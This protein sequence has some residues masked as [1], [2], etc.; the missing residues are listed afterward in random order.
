MTTTAIVGTNRLV[1]CPTLIGWGEHPLLSVATKPLRVTLTTPPNG[2]GGPCVRV[3]DNQNS[4]ESENGLQVIA[5]PNSVSIFLNQEP[6]VVATLL[7]PDTIHI[8]LDLRPLG[9]VLYEDSRGL[10][11]GT[12]VL[13]HNEIRNCNIAIGIG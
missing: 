7:D 10:L 12:N 9:L 3:K 5:E 1:D 2:S 13:A 4:G 8:K 11:I 6:L